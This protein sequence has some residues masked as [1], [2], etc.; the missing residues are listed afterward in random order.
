MRKIS[1]LLTLLG[2]LLAFPAK[3]EKI[4]TL[5]TLNWPPYIGQQLPSNGYVYEIVESAFRRSGFTT[6]IQYYPWARA[7]NLVKTGKIDVLFPE[8]YAEERKNDFIFSDPFPGGPVGLLKKKSLNI[9]WQID[10]RKEPLKA[11]LDLS[12]F[13]FGVIHGY[14]NTKEFDKAAF[15]QKETV[16]SDDLNILKLNAGRIDF[17]FIDKF[18]AQFLI[19][20]KYPQFA[21][22]LEFMEP[23]ME[24]KKLYLAFSKKDPENKTKLKAFNEG[25]QKI[26]KD[27]TLKSIMKKHGFN[28]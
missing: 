28:Y 21:S 20:T 2:I 26:T 7:V 12:Q 9:Q 11:L 8:Y 16:V 4:V 24:S 18:V 6:L 10:P 14:V 19:A 15:L 25:L 13:T 3:G 5:A 1:L 17:I 23:E 27:G 22:T